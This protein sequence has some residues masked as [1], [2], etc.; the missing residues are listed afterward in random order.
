MPPK[1]QYFLTVFA[2]MFLLLFCLLHF[3]HGYSRFH[4][5]VPVEGWPVGRA[6]VAALFF[7]LGVAVFTTKNRFS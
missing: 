3:G 1:T 6:A 5:G 4:P 7:G 2:I